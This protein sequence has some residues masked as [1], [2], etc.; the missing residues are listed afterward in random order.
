[1]D[2]KAAKLVATKLLAARDYSSK[3]LIKKLI[4]RGYSLE[5]SEKITKEFQDFGYINDQQYLNGRI[6]YYAK[7]KK[8]PFYIQ[9]KIKSIG[10]N[11][12][13]EMINDV[14]DDLELSIEHDL[15]YHLNK[16]FKYDKSSWDSLDYSEKSKEKAKL[17]RH[18]ISKGYSH[19]DINSLIEK[20]KGEQNESSNF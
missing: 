1:M 18:L 14:F 4:A 7:S 5:T 8:S 6:R 3:E 13:I 16:K 12:S 2:L 20:V 9:Q 10:F 17:M 15:F 19:F 11:V